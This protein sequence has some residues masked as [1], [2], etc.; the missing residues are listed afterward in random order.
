MKTIR[1]EK[2]MAFRNKETKEYVGIVLNLYQHEKEDNYEQVPQP[3]DLEGRKQLFK[4]IVSRH[5]R[6]MR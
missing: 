5:R 3:D 6:G 2:G 4:A 1:A